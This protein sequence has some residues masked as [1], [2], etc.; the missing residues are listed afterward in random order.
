MRHEGTGALATAIVVVLLTG[1]MTAAAMTGVFP[2]GNN[3][4]AMVTLETVE[5]PH[6]DASVGAQAV[7]GKGSKGKKGSP[8]AGPTTGGVP[9]TGVSAPP[10]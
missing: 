1:V 7:G 4:P 8:A 9:A 6:G 3:S 5:G 10:A 2:R